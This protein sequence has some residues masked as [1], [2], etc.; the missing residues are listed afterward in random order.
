MTQLPSKISTSMS[1]ISLSFFFSVGAHWIDKIFIYSGGE[2]L[3]F[4]CHLE[5]S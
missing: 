3:S 1:N 4:L 5:G 2:T